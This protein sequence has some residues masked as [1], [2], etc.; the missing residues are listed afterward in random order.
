MENK[1]YNPFCVAGFVLAVSFPVL[2]LLGPMVLVVPAVGLTLSIIG[3]AKFKPESE[4][5]QG[6]GIAG[7]AISAVGL[8]IACAF[9]LVVAEIAMHW[10]PKGR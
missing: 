10:G 3:V 2:F 5:G 6:L 9:L 1:S 7:I 8:A 4:K